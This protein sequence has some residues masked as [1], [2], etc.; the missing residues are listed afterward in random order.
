[1]AVVH[2]LAALTIP[3]GTPSSAP[4]SQ[5]L[6]TAPGVAK[7]LRLYVPPGPRGEVALYLQHLERRIAPVPPATWD[8]L[9]DDVV[10]YPLD[11]PLPFGETRFTLCGYSPTA[12]FQH[13]ISFEIHVDTTP[14][15]TTP[16]STQSLLSRLA[17]VLGI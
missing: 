4:A 8:N 5:A 17:G 7:F 3:A 10:E 16:A 6:I 13:I 11:L 2:F 9:D 12:S 15:V 14:S 1:M